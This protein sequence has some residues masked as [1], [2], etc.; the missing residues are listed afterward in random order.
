MW[1]WICIIFEIHGW[2]SE[3]NDNWLL[4][5]L[6]QSLK[7]TTEIGFHGDGETVH[8]SLSTV[9]RVWRRHSFRS[10]CIC[11]W[12]SSMKRPWVVWAVSVISEP[13]IVNWSFLISMALPKHAVLIIDMSSCR[14]KVSG[15]SVASNSSSEVTELSVKN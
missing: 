7:W 3:W 6:K 8:K 9:S 11:F 12:W 4:W 1:L 10:G 13:N 2:L 14:G 5:C 15:N